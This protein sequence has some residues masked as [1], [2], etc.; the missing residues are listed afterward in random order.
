LTTIAPPCLEVHTSEQAAP[1]VPPWFAETLI[2]AE[3]RRTHGRLEARTTQVRLVRGRV[4]HSEVIDFLALWFGY[5][6]SGERTVPAYCQRL[7]PVAAPFMALFARGDLSPP[8][9][10]AQPLSGC[11]RRAVRGSRAG[12]PCGE[13][14]RG[15]RARPVYGVSV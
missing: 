6:L 3:Y 1:S 13:A 5:A 7:A 14:V 11:R 9:R 2:I 12:K 15:S 10:H 4:G 8:S